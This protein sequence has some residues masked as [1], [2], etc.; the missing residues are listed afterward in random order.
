MSAKVLKKRNFRDLS[1]LVTPDGYHLKEGLFFR[2]AAL[3]KLKKKE[4]AQI[5]E[6]GIQ[7]VYDLRT[8]GELSKKPDVPLDGVTYI[9]NPILDAATLGITHEKGLKGYK[10]PPD[11]PSLYSFIVTNPFSMKALGEALRGLFT[12]P[13]DP[14]LWHCSAGKDRAG[15]LTAL[16]LLALGYS[17]E[18]IIKDYELSDKPNRKKG[19]LYRNLILFLLWKRKLAN[20]VYKAMRADPLYLK[21]AFDSMKEV[22]GSTLDYI[23]EKLHVGEDLISAFKKKFMVKE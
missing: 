15:I 7:K 2:S 14:V 12:D 13:G 21:C 18:D 10:A 4:K 17:E 22:A 20:G 3:N 5:E 23:H 19:R 8:D 16:F 1:Y 6:L 11:M 9:H